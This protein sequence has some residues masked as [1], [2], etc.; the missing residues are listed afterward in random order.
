MSNSQTEPDNA[1]RLKVLVLDDDR[2]SSHNLS[3]QLRFVGEV[4][5]VTTSENWQQMLGMLAERGEADS[6]FAVVLGQIR[7]TEL[8]DLLLNLH[9]HNPDLPLLLVAEPDSGQLEQLPASLQTKLLMLGDAALHYQSL[10]DV[11]ATARRV[12]GRQ[13]WQLQSRL[14][15]PSGTAMFRSLNGQSLHMQ[16]IRQLLQQVAARPATVLVT[17]E[18]GTGKEIVARNIH[19]HSG[20]GQRPFIAVNCA[21]LVPERHGSELFGQEHGAQ[22]ATGAQAGLLEAADGGTLFLDEIGDMP[23]SLQAV[24]LRFLEDKQFQRVGGS[25]LLAA[26]VR[27]VAATRQN[28]AQKITQGLFR[29][30]LFYRLSV[31]PVALPPLRQRAEDIPELIRELISRL[32]NRDQTSIRFNSQA[33]MSLQEHHWPGNVRELANLVERLSIMQPNAVIGVG[34][35]PPEYQY[36]VSDPDALELAVPV[37]AETVTGVRLEVVPTPVTVPD[38]GAVMPPLSEERLQQYLDN[39]ERQLFEVALYDSSEMVSFA[40]ERLKLAPDHL[41]ERMQ[42][43]GIADPGLA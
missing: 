37:G 5:L 4:P 32:E 22:G 41:R 7:R 38:L 43:L 9:H 29:E 8:S 34:D 24:L 10:L 39:F 28:L 2:L 40:A 33:L 15:S 14:I 6:V 3:I 12:S 1:P 26:D 20:R 19:Y 23:L 31:V 42:Q 36:P 18:S 35:L 16:R 17:G 11:L 13:G 30:D 21:A 27:I 25:E